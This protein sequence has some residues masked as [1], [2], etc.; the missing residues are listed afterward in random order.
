MA[1]T[2][3]DGYVYLTCS[4][5]RERVPL[6]GRRW[7]RSVVSLSHWLSIQT[8]LV[9]IWYCLAAICDASFDWGLPTP[10]LG[11]GLSY[12]VEDGA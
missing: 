8:T 7:F 5:E 6:G 2:R 3:G 10:S 1:A 4:G 11:K 12:G 9:C